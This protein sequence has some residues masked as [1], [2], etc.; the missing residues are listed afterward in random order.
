MRFEAEILRVRLGL[1]VEVNAPKKSTRTLNDLLV[2]YLQIIEGEQLAAATKRGRLIAL[3]K[4]IL[5]LF[6]LMLILIRW[7]WCFA[8]RSR[9]LK[10][11][12]CKRFRLVVTR[13]GVRSALICVTWCVGRKKI[14][15]FF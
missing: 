14:L 8:K 2:W 11:I 9:R 12:T 5:F 15:K 1:Q 7:V 10:K 3:R 6:S 4:L 13:H